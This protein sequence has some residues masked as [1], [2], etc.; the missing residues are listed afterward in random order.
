MIG[1]RTF[2]LGLLT[3]AIGW[4]MVFAETILDATTSG[5]V[6]VLLG[7]LVCALA[8]REVTHGQ[9]LAA[10][11]G[12]IVLQFVAGHGFSD[13]L[14]RWKEVPGLAT[15]LAGLVDL[16][17]FDAAALDGRVVFHSGQL[18]IDYR[19]SLA[20][21]GAFPL[22]LVF[23]GAAAAVALL[24]VR[25]PWLVLGGLGTGLIGVALLRGLV[26]LLARPL[27]PDQ[28]LDISPWWLL[29]TLLPAALV[30]PRRGVALLPAEDPAERRWAR[31]LAAAVAGIA[32]TFWIGWDDPGA[33]KSGRIVFDDS[34]GAWEPT[35]VAF[36]T[37]GF[38]R[39]YSYTYGNFYDL[40]SWH[41]DVR[42]HREGPITAAVLKDA[43]VL[44]VKTPVKPILPEEIQAIERFVSDGGG[45]FLIGDHTNLFGMTTFIN[46]LAGR[47]GLA[48]RADDTFDLGTE[49]LTRWQ[50]PL[51]LPHP[52]AA[53]VP[54]FQFE[55]SATIVAPLDARAVMVGYGMG[56]EPADF[57]NPGFFGNIHIDQRED[58]GFFL[59]H[60]VLDHGR[61]RVA[62]LSDSTPFSN[63]SIF[64]PG[65]RELAL[66]TVEWLN[67]EA[68]IWRH[69][70]LV[71]GVVAV[72]CLVQLLFA[73]RRRD[74][75]SVVAALIAGLGIGSL[76]L[77]RVAH[78]LTLPQPI[79]DVRTVVFDLELSKAEF[80]PALALDPKYQLGGYDTFF[81]ASQRLGYMPVMSDD[82]ERS[83][84]TADVLV[85]VDPGRSFTAAERQAVL[86]F[87]AAGG[88][89]L[90]VDGLADKGAGTTSILEPFG[91]SIGRTAL[92]VPAERVTPAANGAALVFY[93]P[94]QYV[95]GGF[96]VLTDQDGNPIYSEV[97]FGAG[98]VGV[99]AEGAAVSRAALGNRFYDNPSDQQQEAFRTT[100]V[101][102]RS[103]MG[104]REAP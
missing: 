82:L 96:P 80:P 69:L 103:I 56:A 97:E 59:Q 33:A 29:L 20:R 42:R 68:T 72:L 23:A 54:S 101:I 21:L 104:E 65:R 87:V 26:I 51:W 36:D 57:N 58:F 32:L 30:L 8:V 90:V 5:F 7:A 3:A 13:L 18:L 43:D 39:R 83:L 95:V 91:L 46:A 12:V 9:R 61:G 75:A 99:L 6:L 94:L 37:K 15:L 76:I 85:L 60:V 38:G 93:R 47:F 64:F 28:G 25:R 81:V 27:L 79:H 74:A 17:G 31:P 24:P 45:L 100:F 67:H 40:L 52:I 34:H 50:R 35:D 66:A 4:Q 84:E 98:R 78:A 16:T 48:F 11:I 41:Y 44:I 53:L 88:G 10:I 77:I 14:A 2:Y 73:H 19:P 62:A 71:A 22:A 55:T 89:L 70:P 49:S 1:A 63:F 102:L 92:P 86:R